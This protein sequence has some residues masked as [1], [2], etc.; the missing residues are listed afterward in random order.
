MVIEVTRVQYPVGQGCFHAG[1]I[2][3]SR[4]SRQGKFRYV[5]DCGSQNGT[6]EKRSALRNSIDAYVSDPKKVDALFVSHLDH[7][8]VCGLDHLLAREKVTVHTVFISHLS[9]GARVAN[10]VAAEVEE[11]ELHSLVEATLE[12]ERWFGQRGVS[13]IVM[14]EPAGP[15]EGPP[16]DAGDVDVPGGGEPQDAEITWAEQG[17]G[18]GEVG[19]G[20]AVQESMESGQMLAPGHGAKG[21][22]WVLVPHVDPETDDRLACFEKEVA[23][24]LGVQDITHLTTERLVRALR[25]NKK[26]NAKKG[27]TGERAKLKDC[28]TSC[29]GEKHNR[30]SMSLYSGPRFDSTQK[31]RHSASPTFLC[32]ELHTM[33]KLSDT[34]DAVA[35]IGS[36]DAELDDDEVRKRWF[37]S[38][39]SFEEFIST[40]LLPHHGSKSEF[41]SDLLQ[42]PE[43]FWCIASAGDP[44]QYGH[45][46]IEVIEK[47]RNSGKILHHVSERPSTL[48]HEHILE[49]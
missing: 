49:V 9:V 28:Y 40:L 5:Y 35:W 7:D 15:G 44:S 6:F 17:S 38:Y 23:G 31:W 24:I 21:L 18:D 41:N 20:P 37:Q 8:H 34:S 36:G 29:F 25:D 45:P 33:W 39:Q 43:L 12:P 46:G 1:Y 11:T 14:V 16:P 27:I 4:N 2:E 47:V 30:V 26:R 32:E 19:A 42:F 10:L 3:W 48:F 22:N 13:R